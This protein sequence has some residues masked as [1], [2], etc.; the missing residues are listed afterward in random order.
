MSSEIAITGTPSP[1]A[2]TESANS[3]E[4]FVPSETVGTDR[5]ELGVQRKNNARVRDAEALSII[6]RARGKEPAVRRTADDHARE[7]TQ[8][9]GRAGDS[10]YGNL[11]NYVANIGRIRQE[12][13]ELDRALAEFRTRPD[14]EHFDERGVLEEWVALGGRWSQLEK[15]W[16]NWRDKTLS[17]EAA[18][19][20]VAGNSSAP[21]QRN[22][23][24]EHRL[25]VAEKTHA[26]ALKELRRRED[27]YS[28]RRRAR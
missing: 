20:A 25:S 13:S 19:K 16:Q 24:Q 26:A 7:I 14:V 5:Y 23:L 12:D 27:A 4:H 10:S 3:W 15:A 18:L 21:S 8:E 22:A 1:S 2:T 9:M 17:H 11:H 28:T 6:Q